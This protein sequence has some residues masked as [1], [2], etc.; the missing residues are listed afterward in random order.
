MVEKQMEIVVLQM[1]NVIS[2]KKLVY[3]SYFYVT[4][5]LYGGWGY[6]Y[7]KIPS[8]Y[9]KEAG[10]YKDVDPEEGHEEPSH[11]TMGHAQ[12]LT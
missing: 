2:D 10:A 7:I 6:I 11:I 5:W 4:K 3:E 9:Q 1:V 8:K 12:E